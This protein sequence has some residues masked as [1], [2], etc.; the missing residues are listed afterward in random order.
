M[1]YAVAAGL[2]TNNMNGNP[3][4]PGGPAGLP[5]GRSETSRGKFCSPA[6]GGSSKLAQRTFEREKSVSL[7]TSIRRARRRSAAEA[8]LLRS[9]TSVACR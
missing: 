2:A 8:H 1:A 6:E 9:S 5:N 3:V 7:V 4:E